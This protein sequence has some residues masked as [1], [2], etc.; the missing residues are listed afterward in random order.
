MKLI[1]KDHLP[2]AGNY[3]RAR[4]SSEPVGLVFSLLSC[5]DDFFFFFFST[6]SAP[7]C[8]NIRNPR[9]VRRVVSI[10]NRE[11]EKRAS[12]YRQATIQSEYLINDY[13]KR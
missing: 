2:A 3:R 1:L 13:S 10:L 11:R 6:P 7:F 5:L 4:E 8:A 12:L 9:H